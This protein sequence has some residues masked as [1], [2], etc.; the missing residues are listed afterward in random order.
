VAYGSTESGSSE[1]H[2]RSFPTGDERFVISGGGGRTPI[3]SNDGS[4][5][6]Y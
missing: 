6:F 2:V 4:E 5:L 3:W 1:I